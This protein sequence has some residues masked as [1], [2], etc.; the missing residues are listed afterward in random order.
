MFVIYLG[1]ILNVFGGG[2]RVINSIVKRHGRLTPYTET[3]II[4]IRSAIKLFLENG[5]TKTTFK[6]IEADSGVKI[7]N[8]TYYFHS[9]EELFKVLVEEL[10]DSH[11]DVIEEAYKSGGNH[12]L[13]FATEITVQ[14]ALCE[15][16]RN[17]WDLYYSAYSLPHTYEYIKQW[18]AEK[19]YNLFRDELPDWN[20]HDFRIKEVVTSGIEL[21]ALKSFCDRNFTLDDKVTVVL[22]SIL[23][24][25]GISKERRKET[26]DTI[27]STDYQKTA[28]EMF[29]KFVNRLDNDK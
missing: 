10:I 23:K 2:S 16:N 19:N 28:E 26:I 24:I 17:A 22:D 9:K 18:T 14:L 11:A 5:Y 7:G 21:G 27:L 3:E 4:I 8:I 29:K 20:E 6:M 15:N 25:Y 12:L 1:Y 13:A